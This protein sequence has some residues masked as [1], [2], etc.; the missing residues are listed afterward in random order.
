MPKTVRLGALIPAT[1]TVVESEIPRMLLTTSSDSQV[2]A[3]FARVSFRTRYRDDPLA[4]LRELWDNASGALDELRT[5]SP[6]AVGFFCTSASAISAGNQPC[7]WVSPIEAI[8]LVLRHLRCSRIALLTPYTDAVGLDLSRRLEQSGVTV[9]RQHHF[10]IRTSHQLLS[11]T[12]EDLHEMISR[13]GVD[14]CDSLVMPC[15]NLPTLPYVNDIEREWDMPLVSGVSALLWALLRTAA[16]D[17]QLDDTNGLI[18]QVT[19]S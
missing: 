5:V 13:A 10:D 2:V 19:P 16:P 6:A 12:A 11:L 3:H 7:S 15:T 14:G 1:N 17:V 4:F 9:P 18:F 8:A